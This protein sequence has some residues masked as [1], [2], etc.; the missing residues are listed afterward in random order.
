MNNLALTKAKI[1]HLVFLVCIVVFGIF[2]RIYPLLRADY[3]LVDGGMFYTMIRELQASQFTLPLYTAY[4]LAQ[5]P[6]AYPPLALY[7]AGLL[8]SF[9][10][11]SLLEIL[12]WLPVVV[13]ILIIPVFYIFVRRMLGKDPEAALATL[14]FVLIPNS[15]RWQ[16]VGGGLTR[17]FGALFFLLTAYCASRMYREKKT[18][19][20]IFTILAGSV[21]VLSHLE[22][23]LQAA[24]AGFLFWIFWGR[25]RRGVL[26]TT[27]V[28]AG[29]LLLTSPW[30]GTVIQRHG[31]GIFSNSAAVSPPPW[32]FWSPLL[33]MSFTLEPTVVI[34]V[35]AMLGFFIHLARKDYLPAIWMLLAL[36]VDPRGG[37]PA[38]VFPAAV[39]AMTALSRGIA[40]QLLKVQPGSSTP[41]EW[42]DS[43]KTAVGRLFWGAL[44]L[45]MLYNA[46]IH[47]NSLANKFLGKEE[48]NAM[49]WVGSHTSPEAKFL[50]LGWDKTWGYASLAEWFP[51][52]TGR[53]SINTAQGT[54]WLAGDQG[55]LRQV[56]RYE[57]SY[58]CLYSD[59]S[60]LDEL[61]QDP[62]LQFDYVVL[63]SKVPGESDRQSTL[64]VSL[65][66]SAKYQVV[67]SSPGVGI[68]KLGK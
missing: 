34:A 26:M 20:I 29:V 23:A 60:C 53:R 32:F 11:I 41:G 48:L 19:W 37:R 45:L 38:S 49:Q 17:A 13:N 12:K 62:Q 18:A 64:L 40:P 42:I 63:S 58:L 27:A 2:V 22:W 51:A 16:I 5:I 9:T 52:L 31:I 46:Y 4:N 39:L 56:R 33:S 8:N 65:E 36:M 21:T 1:T 28:I 44:T 57:Q 25:N 47:S 43:I 10:G 7:A 35:L 54:E 24:A 67:Y 6:Y 68:F 61:T 66:N 30:W 50:V 59:S 14:L 3:P 15:Y 55:A